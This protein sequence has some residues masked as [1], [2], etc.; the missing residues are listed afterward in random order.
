MNGSEGAKIPMHLFMPA[1]NVLT[2]TY[3]SCEIVGT[4]TGVTYYDEESLL[5]ANEVQTHRSFQESLVLDG[6]FVSFRRLD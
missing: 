1:R 6:C 2:N 5:L 3:K 4:N